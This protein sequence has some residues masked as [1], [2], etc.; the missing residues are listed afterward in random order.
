LSIVQIR[1]EL[2]EEAH[3]A[4]KLRCVGMG[5]KEKDILPLLVEAWAKGISKEV[6][7]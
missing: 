4:F 6:L 2:S 5:K 3:K 7:K 1:F